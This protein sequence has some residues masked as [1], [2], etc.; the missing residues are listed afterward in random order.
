[1]KQNQF[2]NIGTDV[3]GAGVDV[4]IGI[5]RNPTA[6]LAH[7]RQLS[8]AVGKGDLN[9]ESVDFLAFV[10]NRKTATKQWPPVCDDQPQVG[11]A[12]LKIRL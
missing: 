4:T 1:M 7:R 2:G 9:Q 10:G 12:L 11:I 8:D 3:T 6:D 5:P